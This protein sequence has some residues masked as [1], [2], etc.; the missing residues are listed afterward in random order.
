M[1][2][3][4]V[5]IEGQR[6]DLFDDEQIN[7]KSTQQNVQD[8]SKVF[9]DF[10]QSFSVPAST[11]NNAIFNHFYQNDLSQ[12]IDP[13]I[14]RNA[15]IEIDL[16]LFR[17][18]KIS[19][20]KSEVKNNQAYSYQITFYGDL[21]SLKDT[22][23][24]THLNDLT[25]LE[26]TDFEYTGTNVLN[27]IIDES[28]DFAVRFPFIV[29]RNITYG[30]GGSTDIN[31]STGT[32]EIDYTELFPAVAVHE[33]FSAIERQ[34]NVTFNGLF[35][36]NERF[37]KAFLLCQNANTF[38]FSTAP[39]LALI[40]HLSEGNG[41]QNITQQASTFFNETNNTVTLAQTS[42]PN[43]D[44]FDISFPFLDPPGAF[45][46]ATLNNREH[47]L[48]LNIY[49]TSNN[50]VEYYIDVFL[51][52]QFTQTFTASGSE[53]FFVFQGPMIPSQLLTYQFYFRA[54]SSLTFNYLFTYRQ[55]AVYTIINTS[56]P[57]L[58]NSQELHNLYFSGGTG[59]TDTR[60]TFSTTAILSV[61]NYIPR[62]KIQDFF[63][64]ILQMFNL[65]CYA[66]EKDV[67]Q[68]EPL[69]DWY[70]KGAVIDI[71]QYTDIESIQVDRIKLFKN[72]ELKYNESES[73]TNT[74]FRELTGGRNYGDTSQTFQYDGGEFKIEL[75]FENMMM[76]KFTGTNLQIGETINVDLQKYTP[77]PLIMYQYNA[78]SASYNFNK[79]THTNQ[80]TYIPFGQDLKVNAED[81]TLNFNA[82]ISTFLLTTVQK[83]L[84][85]V[86]YFP[87][88]S[89]LFN[90][91]NRR[92]SVKTNLPISL[93]TNL[94]LNDRVIIRDKRYMIESINSE[95]TTGDVQ[96]VLINDFQD[97]ISDAVNTDVMPIADNTAQCI[98]MPILFP[99]NV[100]S[101]AITTTATGVTIT[102]STLTSEGT[103]IV[104]IP[105]NTNSV[106][107]IS[108][109][110]GNNIVTQDY[111]RLRTE[112]GGSNF[113]VITT[114]YTYADG[115]T[116][117]INTIIEQ[118]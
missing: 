100:V 80:S 50:G 46:V 90:L 91:K 58:G 74:G 65:T 81:F 73:A 13:N 15:F 57:F 54:Q 108:S 9:T 112:E 66:T 40:E 85:A 8:I 30:N 21:I 2:T 87:Y 34:F 69:D 101:A 41:N 104:C 37:K 32:G 105:A 49:N 107:L 63:K 38:E 6:L 77:K 95:I 11:N 43:E 94:A 48:I 62:M 64:G 53:V 1:R 17:R 52:G 102:P 86:Y 36:S 18:G 76:Q 7:V 24:E 68:I 98:K 14:R 12:T 106:N 44:G 39:Q 61:L 116:T 45:E 88:L 19:L 110:D 84:Y 25:E 83:T 4:Q 59:S 111:L 55:E 47:E 113:I 42:F 60:S 82:D 26:T 71:S 16:T 70:S 109:E 92:T 79:G 31:P 23:G 67:Y 89:N 93:L 29:G 33:I 22:F 72:I 28:T 118:E 35:L 3:V 51:N 117:Q 78:Q 10:S 97:V 56:L 27:R 103:T 75:P 5:Y 115:S 20:E 114:T 96:L 99:N